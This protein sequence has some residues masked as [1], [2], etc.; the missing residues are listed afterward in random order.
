MRKAIF[1]LLLLIIPL[2]FAYVEETKIFVEGESYLLNTKNITV[3]NIVDDRI[4][5]SVDSSDMEVLDI[6]ETDRLGKVDLTLNGIIYLSSSES[7]AELFMK[8][9]NKNECYDDLACDDGDS[10]TKDTCNLNTNICKNEDIDSCTD[11]DGYCPL[12]CSDLSDTD[13]ASVCNYDQDCDDN[14][15]CTVDECSGDSLNN[16][17]CLNQILT[18]CSGSDSCCPYGCDY[19]NKLFDWRDSDCSQNNECRIH[20]DCDDGLLYTNDYCVGDGIITERTCL[21]TETEECISND[22]IC[23]EGCD[24][25]VDSDCS[26]LV[27]DSSETALYECPL[28]EVKLENNLEFY[29]NGHIYIPKKIGGTICS[30]DYEC[31][32]NSC[33]DDKCL[34]QSD[35]DDEKSNYYSGVAFSVLIILSLIWVFYLYRSRSHNK[36]L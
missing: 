32:L 22:N 28:G 6:N 11:N 16:G 10:S 9:L 23:P 15:P 14:N 26:S 7:Y 33:T 30:E 29:C 17:Q 2:G 21:N 18:D 4:L 35:I 12:K 5:V 25:G 24:E 20:E 1:I 8:V 34:S 36:N 31:R 3:H 27:D 13:C 19:S